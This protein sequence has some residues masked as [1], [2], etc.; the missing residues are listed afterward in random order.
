ME[1]TYKIVGIQS[2]KGYKKLEL[3]PLENLVEEDIK[4]NTMSLLK[5][6]GGFMKDVQKMYGKDVAMDILRIPDD[7]F[8]EKK[9]VLDGTLTITY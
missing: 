2:M 3:Q 1:Q 5:N 9:L 4:V 8:S 7:V 6:V